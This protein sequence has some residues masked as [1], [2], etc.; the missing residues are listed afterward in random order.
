MCFRAAHGLHGRSLHPGERQQSMGWV[1]MARWGCTAVKVQMAS[2]CWRSGWVVRMGSQAW[3]CYVGGVQ[4]V[5][6]ELLLSAVVYVSYAV[7]RSRLN[8]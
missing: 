4:V 5:L 7:L 8:V 3:Q 2:A 1:D 6:Y